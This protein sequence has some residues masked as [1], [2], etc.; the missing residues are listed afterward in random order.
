M[1]EE[2]RILTEQ[3]DDPEMQAHATYLAGFAQLRGSDPM[4]GFT[5]LTEGV[6]LERAF[7]ESNP[8]LRFAQFMLAIVA[9]R[10]NLSDM[11]LAV[12]EECRDACRARGDQWIQSWIVLVL[13]IVSVLQDRTEVA[14]G[15]LREAIQLKQP[16][17]ELLGIGCSVEM[18]AWCAVATGDNDLAAKLFGSVS[19]FLKPLGLEIE[20]FAPQGEWKHHR[21]H[22]MVVQRTKDALGEPAFVR[23]YQ[24]GTQLTH[25][26]AIALALETVAAEPATSSAG[27]SLLTRREEQIARLLAEGLSNKD[28]AQRLVISQRTAETHVANVLS[29]LGLSSRTQV[30]SWVLQQR[31]DASV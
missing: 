22:D 21:D 31:G 19:V 10:A 2:C 14:V 30:A 15:Q 18:L 29:K 1:M 4:R 9:N 6:E 17:S 8:H 3:F 27:R 26:A 24:E 13:G 20:S 5:M 25:S 7:G 11:V 12:G 16:F 28:I 23:A